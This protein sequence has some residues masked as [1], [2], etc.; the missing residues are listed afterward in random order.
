MDPLIT[1]I[2]DVSSYFSP[3]E[4]VNLH[5]ELYHPSSTSKGKV[6]KQQVS[7]LG[8]TKSNANQ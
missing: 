6:L 5:Y 1:A 8:H 7:L 2:A 3:C 4:G